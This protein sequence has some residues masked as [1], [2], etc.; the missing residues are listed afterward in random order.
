MGS[1]ELFECSYVAIYRILTCAIYAEM[2]CA[3]CA[4]VSIHNCIHFFF[5]LF[6]GMGLNKGQVGETYGFVPY[7]CG[8]STRLPNKTSGL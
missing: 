1:N 6:L 8:Q 4:Y 5:F 2:A 7:C 3:P